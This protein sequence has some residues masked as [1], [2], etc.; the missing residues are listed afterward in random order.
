ARQPRPPVPPG[1]LLRRVRGGVRPP[2]RGP[3]PAGL[4]PA[5]LWADG[6]R[7]RSRPPARAHGVAGGARRHER[8]RRGHR[9][10]PTL[11]GGPRLHLLPSLLPEA[12]HQPTPTRRTHAPRGG[13]ALAGLAR[14]P[15]RAGAR[16]GRDPRGGRPVARLGCAGPL[17]LPSA[18]PPAVVLAD[19]GARPVSWHTA[20]RS[21]G[22][23][24]RTG[25]QDGSSGRV[26]RT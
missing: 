7:D 14:E 16:R 22:R 9:P 11:A 17:G 18:A 23:V 19:E 20:P 8:A 2:R 3:P 4:Q 26:F 10:R 24:F 25:L 12:R 6:L 21:S 15:P 1:G 5:L 13:R